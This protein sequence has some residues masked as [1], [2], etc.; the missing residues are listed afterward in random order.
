M[1]R[2][3]DGRSYLSQCQLFQSLWSCVESGASSWINTVQQQQARA[4]RLWLKT[5]GLS[6]LGI[7][8]RRSTGLWMV[9]LQYPPLL[10]SSVL[11]LSIDKSTT[12]RSSYSLQKSPTLYSVLI[13]THQ[14]ANK[15]TTLPG[16]P[17]QQP[18]CISAGTTYVPD[19]RDQ[20]LSLR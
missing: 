11:Q 19:F 20:Q 10:Q 12:S 2:Y 6:I 1:D 3:G 16:G 15:A 8:G 9:I 4:C 5:S 18:F 14:G 17:G 13:M 7:C